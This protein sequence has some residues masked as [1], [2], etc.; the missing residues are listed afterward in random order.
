M[1]LSYRENTLLVPT[2]AKTTSGASYD[3]TAYPVGAIASAGSSGTTITVD[4]GHSFRVA[5]KYLL[6]PGGANTFS[7]TDTVQSVTATTVVMGQSVTIVSGDALV[8]LGPDTGTS[9][10][11]YDGSPLVIYSDAD[12]ST[13]VSN[14][15]VVASAAGEYSYYHKGDGRFWELVR[16][17]SGTVVDVVKGFGAVPGRLNV[18]DYGA[19]GGAADDSGAISAAVL[20]TAG[21]DSAGSTSGGE[22][23][24][25]AATYT[26]TATV[27]VSKPCTLRLTGGVIIRGAVNPLLSMESS[28]V[29]IVGPGGWEGM[30]GLAESYTAR[31]DQTGSS[32]N[33][34]DLGTGS[35]VQGLSCEGFSVTC[36]SGASGINVKANTTWTF[37]DRVQVRGTGQTGTGITLANFTFNS[38]LK[39]C[40]IQAHSIGLWVKGNSANQIEIVGCWVGR[41]DTGVRL[42]DETGGTAAGANWIHHSVLESNDVYN[43]ELQRVEELYLDCVYFETSTG[44]PATAMSLAI[45]TGT[46]D[47]ENIILHSC[48]FQGTNTADDAIKITRVD[49]LVFQNCYIVNYNNANPIVN[50]AT[51]VADIYWLVNPNTPSTPFTDTTGVVQEWNTHG[52][53]SMAF[54]K[55][56]GIGR[57]APTGSM[58]AVKSA[59]VDEPAII[60]QRFSSGQTGSIFEVA[61]ENGT[62]LAKFGPGA[63]FLARTTTLADDATPSV[64]NG[65]VFITG[66]ATTITD[67]DDG[68]VGQQITVLASEAITITDGAPIIL[69]G[70]A[71]FVMAVADTLTLVMFNDQVWQEISRTVNL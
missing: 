39:D 70:S 69:N 31:I 65:N 52:G 44:F 55:E 18:A 25:P 29:K 43:L 62:A 10:P 23:F 32:G 12:G 48:R 33:A 71:N 21:D 59:A 15:R 28:R 8:N 17:S 34:I 49:G 1:S 16:D 56:V 2:A 11:N 67:F 51:S 26:L 6:G 68:V 63:A 61:N 19:A 7:G 50:D 20:A 53:G 37:F 13:A 42:G 40:N 66:G 3:A 38:R 45:G 24:F 41:N 54:Y 46:I 27:T 9:A 60:A 30:S 36:A 35:A 14:S 5:D 57:N 4:A 47:C 64:R 22:V 58:L